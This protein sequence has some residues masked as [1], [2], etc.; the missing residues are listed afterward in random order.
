M[1]EAGFEDW[2]F[3]SVHFWGEP[4]SGNWSLEVSQADLGVGKKGSGKEGGMLISWQLVFFGT[5]SHPLSE[6]E[7][8]GRVPGPGLVDLEQETEEDEGELDQVIVTQN[9]ITVGI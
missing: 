6:E 9:I 1:T 3:L 5:E 4:A 8:E 2:P 7:G